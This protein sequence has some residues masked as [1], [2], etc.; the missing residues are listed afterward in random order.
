MADSPQLKLIKTPASV[1]E[2]ALLVGKLN[3]VAS[4]FPGFR[5]SDRH[6]QLLE[7]PGHHT[8]P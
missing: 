8:L 4:Y 7:H 6:G 2:A 1:K 3:P 5:I